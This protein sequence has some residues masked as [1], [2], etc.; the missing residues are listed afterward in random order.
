MF[1]SALFS[2]CVYW[3]VSRITQKFLK[4]FSRSG[5]GLCQFLAD[6]AQPECV[7][8][9]VHEFDGKVAHRPREENI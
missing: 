8:A 9:A 1:S 5:N 3:L 2:Q 7:A 4:R 6:A